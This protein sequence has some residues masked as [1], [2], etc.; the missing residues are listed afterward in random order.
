MTGEQAFRLY[1]EGRNVGV[2]VFFETE[3]VF[4]KKVDSTK[5]LLKVSDSYGIEDVIYQ[6]LLTKMQDTDEIRFWEV[7]TDKILTAQISMWKD[8]GRTAQ[9]AKHAKQRF[10][11]RKFMM[12]KDKKGGETK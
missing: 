4:R 7:D 11:G 2:G 8:H 3:G 10:L 12:S 1:K 5:H 9:Y 6:D